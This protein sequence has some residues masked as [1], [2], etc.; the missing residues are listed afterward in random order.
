MSQ[1]RATSDH[2][3]SR[4]RRRW[5]SA[6]PLTRLA[7]ARLPL[8]GGERAGVRGCT[9]ATMA[10]PA[11]TTTTASVAL[12]VRKV[13]LEILVLHALAACAFC[14]LRVAELDAPDLSGQ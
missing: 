14:G 6:P 8:P 2:S 5:R 7:P 12:Q 4:V 10:L 11:A 13:F 1:E 9:S 3:A